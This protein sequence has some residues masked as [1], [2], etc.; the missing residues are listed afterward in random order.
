MAA[1]R[2]HSIGFPCERGQ[3][4]PGFGGVATPSVSIQ[5]GSPARGDEPPKKP[6]AKDLKVFPFNWV[7]LREGTLFGKR[8]SYPASGLFPFNWVPLREGTRVKRAG[9]GLQ[10]RYGFH[11]IGFPCERGHTEH[12]RS[13]STSPHSKFPFN[14]VPLR[15]GTRDSGTINIK[16][17]TVSIQLG[18]PARGDFVDIR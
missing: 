1:Y 5:L 16:K 6:Q 2:F 17:P 9:L 15:E 14:W 4:V 10:G 13:R 7:P 3:S 8:E 18:S 11:S 12:T